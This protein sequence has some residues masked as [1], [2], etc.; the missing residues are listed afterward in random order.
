LLPYASFPLVRTL[1]F[2]LLV[3]SLP[4]PLLCPLCLANP[5]ALPD[6]CLAWL[7][8]HGWL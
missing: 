2:F 5:Q 3:F 4:L 6:Y 8:G 7:P 1:L